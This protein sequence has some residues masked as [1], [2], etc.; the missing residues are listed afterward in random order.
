MSGDDLESHMMFHVCQQ[1]SGQDDND[2]LKE[3][4]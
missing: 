3:S 2:N 4:K 1:S